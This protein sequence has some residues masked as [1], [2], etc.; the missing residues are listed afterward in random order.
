MEP[1]PEPLDTP[2]DA[3]LP[4]ETG[5]AIVGGGIAG[6]FAA[7]YLARRGVPVLLCEKGVVA[8][9]QSG[10]NWGWCRQTLRDPAE[11]PLIR[12]SL[13]LWS[14]PATTDGQDTGFRRSGIAYIFDD[15][16]REAVCTDWHAQVAVPFQIGTRL[17]SSRETAELLPQAARSFRGAIF[18]PTD[19]VAEPARAVPAAARAARAAGAQ[20]VTGCAVRGIET[21]AGRVSGIVTE[22]GRVAC[23]AVVVAAGAWSRRFLGPL[24]LSLPQAQVLASVLRTAPVSGMPD[25]ALSGPRFGFRRRADGGFTVGQSGAVIHD[26]VPDSLRLLPDFLPVW[27]R[28]PRLARPRLGRRFLE[29]ARLPRRWALDAPS[30]FEQVRVLN[31][32]PSTPILDEAQRELARAFPGFAGMKVLARW[33]GIIDVMPDEVPVIS[34]VDQLPGLFVATGFSGHGFG[35]GPGAGH[36]VADLVTGA[37]PI[38]DPAPFRWARFG[39]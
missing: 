23:A 12:E 8:G 24:G 18:T 20:I 17:L 16:A 37:A 34:G 26:I 1:V 21:A 3:P 15:P 28:N 4:R 19:G 30:P 36:L 6:V 5:V 9:E 2:E 14:D 7:L 32:A 10:R 33:G 22:R 31:P 13:R 39:R 27:R 25:I 29:E 35:V 11:V 38:V